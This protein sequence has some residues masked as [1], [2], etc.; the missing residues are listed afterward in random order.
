MEIAKL[1]EQ[2]E[3]QGVTLN[4]EG[5]RVRLRAPADHAPSP[6]VLESLRREKQALLAYLRARSTVELKITQ[7]V[8]DARPQGPSGW[9]PDCIASRERFQQAHAV[10]FPLIGKRVQTPRGPGRLEQVFTD[11]CTVLLE[12]A[13]RRLAAFHPQEIGLLA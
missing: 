6:E 8:S 4:F 11:R 2:L 13:P 7:K 9:S 10:L 1:V 5:D 12:D 3:G